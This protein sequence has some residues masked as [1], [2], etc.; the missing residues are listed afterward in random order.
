[1]GIGLAAVLVSALLFAATASADSVWW[2]NPG[3]GGNNFGHASTAG[4]EGGTFSPASVNIPFG[5][6]IDSATGTAYWA[7][8]Q[9]S[10]IAWEKLDG[11]EGGTVKTAAGSVGFPVGLA[12]DSATGTLYWANTSF[13]NIGWATV[14][15]S[16]GG[17]LETDGAPFE[18]PEGVVIDP[19]LNKLFWGNSEDGSIGYANLDDSGEAGE[20][21]ITGTAPN[22]PDG[23]AIDAAQ[24][25][26]YWTD[27]DGNAIHY[28]P[29]AGGES[30]VLAIGTAPIDGAG[31]LAIDPAAL[32]IYWANAG[33]NTIGEASLDGTGG[34]ELDTGAAAI[35]HPNYPVLFQAP[36]A[37]PRATPAILPLDE[38]GATLSC[39]GTVEWEP[40]L[41]ESFLYRTP[42]RESVSWALNGEPLNG[43]TSRSLVATQPGY[44]TCRVTGAN[45]A[46]STTVT[47]FA[48][49]VKGAPSATTPISVSLRPVTKL[50]I[51]K[52]KYDKGHGTAT[53]LAK[54]SG[55]GRVYLSGKQVV[56]D[57]VR[58]S[59]AGIAK[60]KVAAK[61]GALKTLRATGKAKLGIKL[62]FVTSEGGVATSS[63][64]ITLHLRP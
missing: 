5:F 3:V 45:A 12:L 38:V 36:R 33:S 24:E 27:R 6:V 13:E 55:P 43:A 53:L 21:E 9:G 54:V 28:A 29:L 14:D 64:S 46:G 19:A 7:N 50:Q 15:G 63:H 25:R 8:Y 41:V 58:S 61:G 37:I 2:G 16:E 44:Y 60:L 31:G 34:S 57:S 56:R 49:E 11:S 32:K 4:G 20:L 1:L 59:G 40:D 30:H 23:L 39:P 51:L 62:K 18:D 47:V 26:I 35:S 22:D 52:L 42:E 17:I 10:T 48:A